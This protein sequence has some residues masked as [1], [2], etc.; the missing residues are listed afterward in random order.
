MT[1]EQAILDTVIAAL[2]NKLKE[3]GYNPLPEQGSSN[4]MQFSSAQ[5]KFLVVILRLLNLDKARSISIN[6]REFD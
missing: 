5:G 3:L 4:V 6:Q 2:E 1:I